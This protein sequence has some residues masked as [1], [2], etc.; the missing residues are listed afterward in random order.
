MFI[1][2][3]SLINGAHIMLWRDNGTA[4]KQENSLHKP[5]GG[6]VLPNTLRGDLLYSPIQELKTVEQSNSRCALHQTHHMLCKGSRRGHTV[7]WWPPAREVVEGGAGVSV[8]GEG[9]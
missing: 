1:Y 3:Q 9:P 8:P 4:L 5:N 2:I 7:R 6:S